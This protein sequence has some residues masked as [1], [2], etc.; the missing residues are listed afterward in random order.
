MV[1]MCLSYNDLSEGK[2][3]NEVLNNEVKFVFV[4]G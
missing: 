1:L 4:S 2:A 3:V